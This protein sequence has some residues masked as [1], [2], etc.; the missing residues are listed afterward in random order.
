MLQIDLA[1]DAELNLNYI[2]DIENAKVNCSIRTLI[3][4]ANALEVKPNTLFILA[5]DLLNKE[6]GE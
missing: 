4:V 1:F 5:E 2:S 3:R 6:G